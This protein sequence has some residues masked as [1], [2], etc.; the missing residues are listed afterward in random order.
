MGR[1]P[2]PWGL[3]VG[4]G[5]LGHDVGAQESFPE[6]PRVRQGLGARGQMA[7]DRPC[8]ALDRAG[9]L[10]HPTLADAEGPHAGIEEPRVLL[11]PRGEHRARY[12]RLGSSAGEHRLRRPGIGALG[13]A[14]ES[15]RGRGGALRA[16][17]ES[18]PA[19]ISVR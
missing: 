17:G 18:A 9:D 11:H 4:E 12:P 5:G 6:A 19:C 3:Q 15:V 13:R 1:L 14:R 2:G 7:A 10:D 16:S 8:Q